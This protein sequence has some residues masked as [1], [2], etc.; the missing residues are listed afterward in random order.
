MADRK[1][2]GVKGEKGLYTEEWSIE[3]GNNP[4]TPW[5]TSSRTWR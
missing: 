4:V 3:N 5:Y 2:F 1:R